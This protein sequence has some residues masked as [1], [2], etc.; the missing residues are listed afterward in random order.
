MKYVVVIGDGMGDWPLAELNGKTPL[1]I[2]DKPNIDNL[3][4]KGRAGLLQTVPEALNPGSDVANMSIFGYNPLEYYSGRGPLEAGGINIKL[5]KD[6]VVFRCNLITEEDGRLMSSN[7]G[8]IGSQ[9]AKV[10]INH[11]NRSLMDENN[12]FGKFLLDDMNSDNLNTPI[13]HGGM[14]YKHLFVIQDVLL[15][16]VDLTPP[17]DILGEEINGYLS[18]GVEGETIKN[19]ILQSKDV[20]ENH[21]INKKR[22]KQ[23]KNPANMIW[24]WGQGLKPKLP[25]FKDIHGVNG[26]VITGVDLLKGIGVFAGL[27]I[28]NVPGATAFYDTDYKAKGRYGVDNLEKQD[29]QFIHIESPDEAGHDGNVEE[30]IKAIERIDKHIVG[31]ILDNINNY[32]DYKIAVLPD[33]FTPIATRT[34]SRDPVPL[35]IY[36]STNVPDEVKVYDESSVVDGSLNMDKGY[37]LVKRLLDH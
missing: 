7:A 23:G 33:H 5:S 35:A 34:H 15:S 37:N 19:L 14:D 24:L 6:E 28:I 22:V 36:S 1:Q 18:L 13:F 20:L 30:K 27:D 3:T 11:L 12:E 9:E 29:V 2:A 21:P 10:L 25:L 32:E 8:H 17:H 26:S 4:L 31:Q 16:K